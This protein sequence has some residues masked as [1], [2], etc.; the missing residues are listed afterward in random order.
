[1]TD[2]LNNIHIIREKRNERNGVKIGNG[3][4]EE[5]KKWSNASVMG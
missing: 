4:I 1:M 3:I 5:K 2:L